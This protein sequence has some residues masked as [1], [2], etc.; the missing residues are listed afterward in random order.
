MPVI[1]TTVLTGPEMG[2]I[3]STVG[4]LKK[5]NPGKEAAPPKVVTVIIPVAPKLEIAV[6]LVEEFIVNELA[7][8][9][10]KLT[11]TVFK[12]L[13]PIIVTGVPEIPCIGEK[14]VRTGAGTKVNP[15]NNPVPY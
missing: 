5:V 7:G 14:E 9:P 10:P 12:R 3:D 13:V 8:I 1:V 2:V 15:L 4:G 6:I 11:A